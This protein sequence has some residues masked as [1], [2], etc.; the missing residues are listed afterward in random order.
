M[1]AFAEHRDMIDEQYLAVIDT[2]TNYFDEVISVAVVVAHKETYQIIEERYYIITPECE[3][4]AMYE[5]ALNDYPPFSKCNR[6]EVISD[7]RTLLLNHGVKN[8]FAYNAKFDYRHLPE[9]ADYTWHDIM[10]V[11]AYRQ[12]NPSITYNDECYLTGRLK[13]DYGVQHMIR[14][15]TKSEWYFEKHNAA[16][17][18][19]DELMIMQ[20]IGYPADWYPSL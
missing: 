5:Y 11:A 12:Y 16:Y 18:A 2:E 8:I 3:K 1:D 10:S 19:E 17:D 20:S 6:E 9:L 13:R 15:L 7:L 4:P 14:R